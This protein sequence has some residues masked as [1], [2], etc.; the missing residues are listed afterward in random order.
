MARPKG[1]AA[2]GG[3]PAG[4]GASEDCLYLNVWTPAKA[5]GDKLPVM[6][7]TYG[8]GFT[9]GSGSDNWYDGEGPG[10]RR[11]WWW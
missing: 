6:I 1:G 2:R 7:W 10:Q 9:G 5:A 3:A 8:G 11:E 4:P